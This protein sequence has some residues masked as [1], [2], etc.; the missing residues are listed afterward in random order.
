[1]PARIIR[2]EYDRDD[3]VVIE[4]SE[5]L[6]VELLPYSTWREGGDELHDTGQGVAVRYG[7]WVLATSR[8]P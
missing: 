5:G 3:G 2:I 6:Q 4:T 8:C 7:S 1:M